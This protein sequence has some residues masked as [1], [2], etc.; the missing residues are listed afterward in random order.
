MEEIV[1]SEVERFVTHHQQAHRVITRWRK[2]LVGFASAADPLFDQLEQVV[3]PTH[4]LPGDLLDNARTVVVFF[5]PFERSVAASNVEGL[6]ASREWATAYIETNAL[7]RAINEHMKRY[8]ET[9][10]Y[11]AAMTPP[12]HN[13]DP[14][15]LISDWSHRHIAYIAGLGRF[16]VNNM[17]ITASGCC[18]RFGSFVTDAAVAPDSGMLA[19]TCLYRHDGSCL[20]CVERCQIGALSVD[21][22]DRHRCYEMCL[23]NEA[24]FREIG[25][26]D[27]CG[28]CL[29]GLPCSFTN[30]VRRRP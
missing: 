23:Q 8:F 26:A 9:R 29:V 6:L 14:Q 19:E 16:G 11:A 27:V 17:L 4:L 22:F 3:A 5:I 28:K 13:F 18:G 2:P 25:Q 10:G 1:R 7:I 24:A 20:R 15:R 30:P 21:R 12:T